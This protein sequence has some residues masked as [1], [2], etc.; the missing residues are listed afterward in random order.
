[1]HGI[2]HGVRNIMTTSNVF[3]FVVADGMGYTCRNANGYGTDTVYIIAKNIASVE[4]RTTLYHS[5]GYAPGE[6]SERVVG[7]VFGAKRHA[8]NRSIRCDRL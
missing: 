5:R 8:A 1:M 7:E 2:I 3:Q 4:T 6:P